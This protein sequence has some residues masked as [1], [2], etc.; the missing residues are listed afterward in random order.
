LPI[1]MDG[2]VEVQRDGL[3]KLVKETRHA[4]ETIVCDGKKVRLTRSSSNPMPVW[5]YAVSYDVRISVDEFFSASRFEKPESYMGGMPFT[6]V[7]ERD[8]IQELARI[9]GYKK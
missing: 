1:R 4:R 3:T 7:A 6:I 5:P 9:F 2:Y 8:T